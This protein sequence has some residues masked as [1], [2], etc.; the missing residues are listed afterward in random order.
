M[1]IIAIA[2]VLNFLRF[3]EIGDG[4]SLLVVRSLT[5]EIDSLHDASRANLLACLEPF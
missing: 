1:M 2:R 5:R 4:L 3:L